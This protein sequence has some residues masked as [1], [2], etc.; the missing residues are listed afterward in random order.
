MVRGDVD[1][2]DRILDRRCRA[3]VPGLTSVYDLA[4]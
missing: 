1:P 2:I 4:S 3:T